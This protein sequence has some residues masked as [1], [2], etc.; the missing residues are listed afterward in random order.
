MVYAD[1]DAADVLTTVECENMQL[2]PSYVANGAAANNFVEETGA[3]ASYSGGRL[4][5][6]AKVGATL[7]YTFAGT[8]LEFVTKTG[9]GAAMVQLELFA[10]ETAGETALVDTKVDLYSATAR[11][12]QTVY[13]K[14]D[15]AD[16]TYT[17][18]MTALQEKNSAASAYNYNFDCVHFYSPA[19]AGELKQ[20]PGNT[21]Y[22]LDS[23]ASAGGDGL[24]PE[25]AWN[26][27]DSP[28]QMRF[29]PGDKLLIAADSVF[30]GQLYPKGSGSAAAP[31]VIDRYGEGQ[32][33]LID[34]NGRYGPTPAYGAN[35]PFGE[36][37][38]AVYLLNSQYWEIN[39]LRVRNW[40]ESTA[41]RERSGI[42]VEASGGGVYSHIYIRDCD[43]YDVRGYRG[44]DSI[45]NEGSFYGARTTHRT[46]G[47][48]FC[49][50]TARD[51]SDETVIIDSE[52]T[53][54]NDILVE[55]NT[56][57]NCDANGITT[58]NV[59]GPLD[60]RDYRHT[61]VVI[62]GNYIH[63][64]QRSGII[65]IY[66]SGVLAEYNKIDKFQQT[67]EGYGCGIW[68]DRGNDMLYQY[69]EICNGQNTYDGMAF[70]FDDMTEDGV[71]QY[72]YTHNNVGGGV[73]LHVRTGSYN[74]NNVV[75]YNLSVNDTC[76]FSA[77]QAMIVA[78]GE[79]ATTKIEDAEVYNNTFINS[80]D[81]YPVYMGDEVIYTNNIFHL[82]HPNTANRA[83]AY[84]TVGVNSIFQNNLFSGVHAKDEPTGNGNRSVADVGFHDTLNGT[85]S[86]ETA[87]AAAKLITGSPA[88]G[89]GIPVSGAPAEDLYGNALGN[90]PNVGAYAGETVGG[91]RLFVDLQ[92]QAG[93]TVSGGGFVELEQPATLTATAHQGYAFTG[94]YQGEEL[95]S[96]ENP[97]TFTV[98]ESVQLT[99][100]FQKLPGTFTTTVVEAEDCELA[101][102]LGGNAATG[103]AKD[104]DTASHG[105][106][107]LRTS[108]EGATVTLNFTG[109]AV[110]FYTKQG[111]G[112]GKISVSIDGEDC[113]E[114]DLYSGSAIF[115]TMV[116]EKTGLTDAAH[117]LVMTTLPA[118]SRN[119]SCTTDTPML[120]F[121]YFEITAYEPNPDPTLAFEQLRELITEAEGL[122]ESDFATE[123][124]WNTLQA[125]ISGVKAILENIESTEMDYISA[126]DA[127]AAAM[128]SHYNPSAP[129]GGTVIMPDLKNIEGAADTEIL[130]PVTVSGIGS[131]Y[132]S[133]EGIVTIPEELDL[134]AVEDSGKLSG[135]SL[136]AG[137]V[138]GGKLRFAYINTQQDSTLTMLDDDAVL[139]SLRLKLNRE[140]AAGSQLNVILDSLTAKSSED[141][142]YKAVPFDVTKAVSNI[143]ISEGDDTGITAVATELYTGD[144][145]DLIPADKKAVSIVFTGIT[146]EQDVKF[147][148]IQLYYNVQRS[149]RTNQVVYVGLVDTSTTLDALRDSEGYTIADSGVQ[150]VA[151]GK[152]NDQANID[153]QDALNILDAWLRKNPAETDK[154]ILSM[155]VTSD[156]RI[157]TTD[158]LAVVDHFVNG[159]DFEVVVK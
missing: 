156:E 62:R 149:E 67:T 94:W 85:E 27:L 159:R 40:D 6:T 30:L 88:I 25:R 153:A 146:N 66:T 74:R 22:Y 76:N 123:E 9:P 134:V 57:I 53:I 70:N 96:A 43:V 92:A 73:M 138:A 14:R 26:T 29:A 154:Q 125:A 124:E 32:K 110:R 135:G 23:A 106:G 90:P 148:E 41:N 119:P 118:S 63:D 16:G 157:D 114:V 158:V 93:G 95:A 35:G 34:G 139:F 82:T 54:F 115:Q 155:N 79:N 137:G 47:I 65:P 87:L 141:G 80:N 72:N 102:T 33:P 104:A 12:K 48:N 120:N 129:D 126:R 58:T 143:T 111:P 83:N 142:V 140:V 78:V 122:A 64:V 100:R 145:V 152:T 116:F 130:I 127:L 103:F 105:G 55:D 37:G 61:N 107:H 5:K 113:G 10:G 1:A 91:S 17:L 46:G 133:L 81:V 19:S 7:T 49:S 59:K 86:Q 128:G 101:P 24:S 108:V 56:V 121:D 68:N 109:R 2:S 136:N 4:I 8:G 89:A 60:D 31:I 117:V 52:P 151:F 45:W 84:S 3:D 112:A 39:N 131:E 75:R 77:H 51:P 18:R 20:S 147:G 38:S 13:S 21:S 98:T 36:A 28:N 42:R 69:N 97:Y 44:Q 132:R 144:G 15:L 150:N 99:A 50:Y 71:I 11:F